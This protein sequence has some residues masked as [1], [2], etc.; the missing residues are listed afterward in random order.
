MPPPPHFVRGRILDC[1]VAFAPRNDE[2]LRLVMILLWHLLLIASRNG[3]QEMVT[4]PSITMVWPV[5]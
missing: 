1:F 4:P 3:N 2:V 5:M